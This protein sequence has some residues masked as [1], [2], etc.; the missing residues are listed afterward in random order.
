MI[1][2]YYRKV[3]IWMHDH[4]KKLKT[5]LKSLPMFVFFLMFLMMLPCSRSWSDSSLQPC[6]NART[7]VT[8]TSLMAPKI[9]FCKNS[10]RLVIRVYWVNQEI[11]NYFTLY[12]NNT[13][14]FENPIFAV[15]CSA[16]T[17]SSLT[18]MGT[19]I[20]VIFITKRF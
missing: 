3:L 19:K 11:E 4:K 9:I 18:E 1:K 2:E 17:I 20:T 5:W 15:I 10:Q 12:L 16:L 14:Y 8:R 7:W 6:V 13:T